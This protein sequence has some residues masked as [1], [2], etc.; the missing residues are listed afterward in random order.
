MKK[1]KKKLNNELNL[2]LMKWYPPS[3]ALNKSLLSEISEALPEFEHLTFFLQKGITC[4]YT[5]TKILS[6]AFLAL[7]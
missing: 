4:V 3:M 2:K 6:L 5:F 1:N 7:V